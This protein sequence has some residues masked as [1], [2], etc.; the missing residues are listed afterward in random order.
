MP[1]GEFLPSPPKIFF[2]RDELVQ[3]VVSFAEKLTSMALTGTGG[4]G[5]TS[6]ILAALHDHRIKERFGDNRWFIR[7]DQFPASH[8]HFLRKLSEATGAGI[9]NPEDLAS[10][11]RYLSSKEMLIVLDNAESILGLSETNAQETHTIV[12]ELSQYDNICLV[13]T[14]CDSNALPSQCEV[15]WIP[16]LAVEAGLKTFYR[17]HR[18][19][20]RSDWIN[21]ILKELDFH[22]LSMTLL[23]TVAQQNRWNSRLLT[24]EWA[25]QRTGDL[26]ARNLGSLAV[27]TEFSLASPVFQELGPNAREVL[28]VIAFFPQGVKE[29]NVKGLFPT[30]SDGPSM[31]DAFCK[32]SLT[33]RAHGFITM[34]A[35]LRDHLRPKNPMASPL[36]RR[37][38][39]HYFR[40]LSV[41]LDPDE[42]G[43]DEARWITSED[44]NVEHLLDVFT[45]IDKNSRNVWEACMH[46]MNHLR[47]HKPRLV[48]LGPKVEALP[49]NDPSKLR[50]MMS[51]SWLFDVVGNRAEGKRILSQSLGLWRQEGNDYM[52][53]VTLISLSDG[54]RVLDLHEEGIEQACEALDIFEQLGETDQQIRCLVFLAAFLCKDGQLDAAEE[55]ASQ[56]M[57]LSEDHDQD[58][59][60]HYH[61]V[62]AEIQHSKGNREKAIHHFEAS[63]RIASALNSHDE[64]SK[65]HL[66][67]ADLYLD[68]GK[69]DDAQG[70]IEHSKSHAGNNMSLLGCGVY[71][72]ARV[73]SAQNRPEEAKSE[74]LGAI[75][76]FEKLGNT[77]GVDEIR[78]FVKEIE[79][80]I[81][82]SNCDG[83]RL[84][85]CSLFNP[86]IRTRTQNPNNGGQNYLGSLAHLSQAST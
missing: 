52:V 38:K 2:G 31:L 28:G 20:E 61:K 34:L 75:A 39:E 55:A 4:I 36:L 17:I 33:Y 76:I 50:C 54:N 78:K 32:L 7:C 21:N 51:L 12:D 62:L 47:C 30:I 56:A 77:A 58:T 18:L 46:F 6:I 23:A 40:R 66:S 59:L 15:I 22:P 44:V 29:A 74:A 37:A 70:H 26:R 68:E 82:E 11:R 49:D 3:R 69:F 25:K 35:P 65:T 41:E 48:V 85:L 9:K 64:L 71:V 42:P 45:S 10:M 27:I 86:L 84:K 19:G 80:Q 72:G 14:S 1:R 5:K 43:F 60:Y 81:E 53:A 24:T 63:L 67:M 16:T 13:V 73:L 57:D 83:K 79:E 8:T